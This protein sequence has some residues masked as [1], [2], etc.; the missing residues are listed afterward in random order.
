MLRWV[1]AFS[2]L[3]FVQCAHREPGRVVP[4]AT[5][6]PAAPLE[7]CSAPQLVSQESKH[8]VSGALSDLNGRFLEAHARARREACRQLESERL[9]LRYSFG[10]LEARYE[11]RPLHEGTIHVIPEAYHPLKDVS[12]AVFSVALVLRE[13]RG[14]GR[15]AHAREVLGAT[16]A[17]LAELG[18]PASRAYQLIPPEHRDRQVRLLHATKGALT[19][20]IAGRLD[21]EAQRDYFA[22]VEPDVIE[23]LRVVA[24]ALVRGLHER[25]QE[26]RAIVER[27]DPSAW[28]S[29]VVVVATVHQA[30]AR[31]IG[32]QYF[33]RLLG[34][35]MGE[36]ASLE[37]RLVVAESLFNGADQY[38]LLAAHLVDQI[39]S[40]DVFGDAFRLQRDALADDGGMLD[41]LLPAQRK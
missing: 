39:G 16:E 13:P 18:D 37:R 22:R 33:E 28:D 25:V 40:S 14:S 4:G 9:V 41:T 17:V 38:G 36:G 10:E 21:D 29:L 24:A 31:E 3:L 20:L 19:D 11:G 35:T 2:V 7:W 15:T 32:V 26:L 1:A 8:G 30:R 6:P 5:S 34:E 27:D 23:N 12:H